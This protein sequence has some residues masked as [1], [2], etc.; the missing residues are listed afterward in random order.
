[1]FSFRAFQ[2]VAS[3]GTA[4]ASTVWNHRQYATPGVL[5]AASFAHREQKPL[6]W[7]APSALEIAAKFRCSETTAA[8]LV[9]FGVA[10]RTLLANLDDEDLQVIGAKCDATELKRVVSESFGSDTRDAK[11]FVPQRR[12]HSIESVVQD[13]TVASV[14]LSR[15]KIRPIEDRIARKTTPF[16]NAFLSK[17]LPSNLQAKTEEGM[18]SLWKAF[19]CLE[20]FG[21][22][23]E[24]AFADP[25]GL[26][27]A[28]TFLCSQW[29]K[30]AKWKD[31][32]HTLAKW[33]GWST[34]R[35]RDWR[36]PDSVSVMRFLQSFHE[37][38]PTVPKRHFDSLRWLEQNFGVLFGTDLTRVRRIA[39]PPASHTATQA[40]PYPPV[41]WMTIENG[42]K[43][44]ERVPQRFVHLGS[45]GYRVSSEAK[46]SSI[47]HSYD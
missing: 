38:G 46:A 6:V 43:S 40:T 18:A 23:W 44:K 34:D 19:V 4:A 25:R 8:T 15:L 39:D 17:P 14:G 9:D 7:A 45:G 37:A 47:E 2:R 29:A 32:K 31:H 5:V 42:A 35:E 10:D 20:K 21:S 36:T 13:L 16:E 33:M 30:C 24:S 3:F 12:G 41:V 26:E 1:M 11:F 22:F 28:K 27:D